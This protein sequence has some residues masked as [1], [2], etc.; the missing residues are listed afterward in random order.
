ML[1]SIILR[2]KIQKNPLINCKDLAFVLDFAI[3]YSLLWNNY[4][5]FVF[6]LLTLYDHD[7]SDSSSDG[8]LCQGECLATE[9][10]HLLPINFFS[11]FWTTYQ[12]ELL[13]LYTYFLTSTLIFP[14]VKVT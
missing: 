3:F 1:F 8:I 14:L 12:Q 10:F 5:N 6:N 4:S 9:P 2:Q 7:S 11:L 13:P